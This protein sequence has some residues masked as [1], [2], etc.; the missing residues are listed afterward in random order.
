MGA[1]RRNGW[2]R[3]DSRFDFF[4][5]LPAFLVQ[6]LGSCMFNDGPEVLALVMYVA[7]KP[8]DINAEC[9]FSSGH[10]RKSHRVRK[11]I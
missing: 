5:I 1:A 9:I 7:I 6:D 4:P 11:K 3:K 2:G 10:I 8:K